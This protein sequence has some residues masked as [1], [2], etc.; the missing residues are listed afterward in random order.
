MTPRKADRNSEIVRRYEAGERSTDLA[1]EFGLHITRIS[2]IVRQ[3]KARA[4]APPK[5]SDPD[6][7]VGKFYSL[8]CGRNKGKVVEAVRFLGFAPAPYDGR[9]VGKNHPGKALWLVRSVGPMLDL[10]S[11]QSLEAPTIASR[12]APAEKTEPA[13]EAQSALSNALDREQAMQ[14]KVRPR[15]RKAV[16]GLW[17]CSDGVI[18]RAARSFQGAY[19]RWLMAAIAE[20][21]RRVAPAAWPEPAVAAPMPKRRQS[22]PGK[23]TTGIIS[24]PASIVPPAKPEPY[25]GPVTVVSGTREFEPLKLSTA[26]RMNGTRAAAAQPRMISIAGGSAREA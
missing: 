20:E 19:Q 10:K 14:S 13:S 26:L 16:S 11:K 9:L 3:E 6:V 18:S 23:T 4:A 24:P 8:T 17:E 12:L 1:A 21:E 25:T 15:I 22:A 5:P 7:E 2:Q